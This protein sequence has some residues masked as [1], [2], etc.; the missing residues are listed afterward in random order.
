VK[1]ELARR[2]RRF[3]IVNNRIFRGAR[4]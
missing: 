2:W 3:E 4:A 1:G